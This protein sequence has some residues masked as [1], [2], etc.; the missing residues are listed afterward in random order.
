MPRARAVTLRRDDIRNTGYPVQVVG[1]FACSDPFFDWLWRTGAATQVACMEDTFLDCPWRERGLYT[2][3]AMVQYQVTR[4]LTADARLARRCL[5][6]W[7]V[8]QR[9]DGQLL[10]VVPTWWSDYVLHDFSLFWLLLRGI[11]GRLGD[12]DNIDT[13][14][15]RKLSVMPKGR[16]RIKVAT[17]GETR[18]TH[19]PLVFEVSPHPLWLMVPLEANRVPV[20]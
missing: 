9:A 20:E 11:I 3:D 18:W 14:S 19:T 4:A 10:A 17:D 16:R 1:S 5:W 6:L 15:F 12:A 7:S 13:F 2:A 8:N